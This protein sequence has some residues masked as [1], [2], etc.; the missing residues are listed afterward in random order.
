MLGVPRDAT[1]AEI[2]RAYRRL[3]LEHHPDV[4]PGDADAPA[5][6]AALAA[7]H[8]VLGEAETRAR[9]DAS[10]ASPDAPIVLPGS[11]Q[12]A[13]SLGGLLD[14]LFGVKDRRPTRGRD[15]KY[16][17]SITFG[18]MAAGTK[19]TLTLPRQATCPTC[20]GRGFETGA[21]PVICDRCVGAGAVVVRRALRSSV[22]P[23]EPCLGRGYTC[24]VPCSACAGSGEVEVPQRVTLTVPSNIKDGKVLVLR[25]LGELGKHGGRDGDLF[26]HVAV[27]AHALLQRDGLDVRLE[28]PLPITTAILG[29]LIQVPTAGGP[30][31]IR[32]P[33]GASDGL[34]LR[35]KGFGI[36]DPKTG[37]TGDQRITIRHE[38][39]SSLDDA[40]RQALQQA[41]AA[42]GSGVFPD[43]Q[44]FERMMDAPSNMNDGQ[45]ADGEAGR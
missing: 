22:E 43:T 19:R 25:G 2:K 16:T 45:G 30:T 20:S 26:V 21:V 6:F 33:A 7:A 29:G 41:V 24:P 28:R 34:V 1:E 17:L 3:A 27:E 23:C 15:R 31:S 12:V 18:E 8:A 13:D 40:Q 10:L 5:R 38:M 37:Q 4:R 35:L 14:G 36:V 39:P 11:P 44:A 42:L 32:I 9:Y